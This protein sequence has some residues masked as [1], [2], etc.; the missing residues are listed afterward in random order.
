MVD[1]RSEVAA[2]A[3]RWETRLGRG[4]VAELVAG[5]VAEALVP[6]VGVMRTGS[7][8][9]KTIKENPIWA[10]IYMCLHCKSNMRVNCLVSSMFFNTL[11][12][13]AF[14]CLYLPKI[15]HGLPLLIR[16]GREKGCFAMNHLYPEICPF[17]TFLPVAPWKCTHS[18]S[19]QGRCP[20]ICQQKLVLKSSNHRTRQFIIHI[21]RRI[22]M[23]GKPRYSGVAHSWFDCREVGQIFLKF[24]KAHLAILVLVNDV[25]TDVKKFLAVGSGFTAIKILKSEASLPA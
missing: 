22:D 17:S 21:A 1:E 7:P 16:K 2:L 20:N 12:R 9:S 8:A 14:G 18:L 10:L 13:K 4:G 3:H 25:H 5:A 19:C 15:F 11:Q 6:R 23:V 24:I